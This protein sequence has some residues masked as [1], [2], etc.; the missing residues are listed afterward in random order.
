MKKNSRKS[1]CTI[2]NWKKYQ[3]M[4]NLP[5]PKM[6]VVVDEKKI[7]EAITR[8]V[9][10]IFPKREELKKVLISGKRLRLY[11]GIDPT[12]DF[13]H[14]GHF[15]WMR[16]LAKFQKLGHQVIFLIG[17]FTA[18]IGDPDKMHERSALTKEQVWKNFESYKDTASR[19]IDFEWKQNPV[20][21]LNNYDWLSKV[22]LEDWLQIMSKVTMQHIL[23]HEMFATRLK[24]QLPLRLHEVMYPLM[25]GFDGV[26]MNVDL[27]QGGSDQT[28]NMLTGRIL[29]KELIGKEKFVLTNKLI[30]DPTGAK[31]GKTTDNAISSKDKPEDMYG[32]IMSWPDENLEI[33]YELLTD[34]D[35]GKVEKGIKEGK[36]MEL[37]KQLA[38]EIV[39]MVKSEEKAKKAQEHFEK[40]VQKGETPDEMEEIEISLKENGD[41]NEFQSSEWST[42]SNKLEV[43]GN[44]EALDLVLTL[45]DKGHISSHSEAKR[46]IRQGGVLVDKN[47]ITELHQKIDLKNGSIVKIGK[48]SYFK[49]KIAD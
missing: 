18:M 19:F 49:I 29:S 22:T 7:D 48:R 47:K 43:K 12:G 14:V 9:K 40:T 38:F 46:L 11:T 1:K 45:S 8:G 13:L 17:G 39:K 37:K 35:L 25:Q 33:S 26:V 27:E 21:I 30:V 41:S 20:T 32:K 3:D 10:D 4:V 6:E 31:M 24:K 5:E 16:R 34:I 42:R 23:S 15:I 44:I 28:F 2:N 36:Q